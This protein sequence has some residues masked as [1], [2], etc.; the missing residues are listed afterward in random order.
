MANTT[1]TQLEESNPLELLNQLLKAE[2]GGDTRELAIALGRPEDEV[3]D[4]INGDEI[5]DEDA[6]MKIRGLV[7]ER[8]GDDYSDYD[9]DDADEET[10]ADDEDDDDDDLDDDA[11]DFEDGRGI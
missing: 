1:G 10:E 4:W 11:Q 8:L 6:E 9:E 7:Q 3:T 5:I 2:F